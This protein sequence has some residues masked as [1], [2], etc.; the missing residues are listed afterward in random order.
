MNSL[1]KRKEQEYTNHKIVY[2]TKSLEI[3]ISSI[4]LYLKC[5][6]LLIENHTQFCFLSYGI[7]YIYSTSW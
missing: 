1:C 3:V 7:E 6:I 5:S 4:Q 2:V